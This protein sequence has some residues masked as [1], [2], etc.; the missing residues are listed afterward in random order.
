MFKAKNIPFNGEY[1]EYYENGVL[2]EHCFYKD[3]KVDGKC[4]IW[5]MNGK[6]DVIMYYKDG[7]KVKSITYY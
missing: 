7:K 1:K 6:L 5:D 2:A 3:G 4:K